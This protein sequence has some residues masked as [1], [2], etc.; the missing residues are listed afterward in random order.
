MPYLFAILMTLCVGLGVSSIT[1]KDSITTY[2]FGIVDFI[3][4][5]YWFVKFFEVIGIITG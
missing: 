1:T 2:L 4:A 5:G 3:L